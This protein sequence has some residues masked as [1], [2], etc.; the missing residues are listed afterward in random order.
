MEQITTLSLSSPLELEINLTD[1]QFFQLCQNNRDLRFERTADG[2]LIIMPPTGGTTSDRNAELTYQLRAWS[3]Q[4]N[5]GKSFDSSGGFKLPNGADRS[6]D[7]SWVAIERWNALT[8]EQQEKF[9]PFCPD[10]V[11]ELRSKSDVFSKVQAKMQEYI[12][13]GAKLGWLIDPQRKIVEIYRP[14]REVQILRSPSTLSG[15]DVLPG[16]VLDLSEIL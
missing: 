14:N 13:N 6:P 7:A 5:L 3:R 10:F 2:E 9:V 15:E 4:N 12:D 16:F 1:E 8:P 11:V